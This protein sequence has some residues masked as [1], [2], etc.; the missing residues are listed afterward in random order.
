MAPSSCRALRT[1]LSSGECMSPWPISRSRKRT[2]SVGFRD[3]RGRTSSRSGTGGPDGL[4]VSVPFDYAA[5]ISL[6]ILSISSI[7]GL[8]FLFHRRRPRTCGC[9]DFF[10]SSLVILEER[11]QAAQYN[12]GPPC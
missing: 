8:P 4:F 7:T 5:S 6:S 12:S 10:P 2:G 1:D 9:P 3:R 11:L